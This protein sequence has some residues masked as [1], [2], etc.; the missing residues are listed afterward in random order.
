M[1]ATL[2]RGTT[3]VEL[4]LVEDGSGNPIAIRGVGKP[5][6]RIN[7]TGSINPRHTDQWSG[8]DQYTLV[9]RFIGTNAYQD[10]LTLADLA[11][12]NGAGTPLT[13]N[14]DSPEFDTDITVVP[15]A[16]Q[17]GAITLAYEPGTKNVVI[18]DVSLTRVSDVQGS[19]EQDATTP[20]ASGNGPIQLSRGNTTVD[21]ELDVT[22]DRSIG[23]PNDTTKRNV[24]TDPYY[25]SKA[26][27]AYDEFELSVTYTSNTISTINDLVDIFRP[28]LGRESLT[29]DFNGLYGMGAMSVVPTGSEAIRFVRS[30]GTNGISI[31]PKITLRR[32]LE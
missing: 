28:Q 4:P 13:L 1:K 9:G 31:I 32:V 24:D 14:I 25:I 16:G 29:L 10:A 20:T 30:S 21:L 6:L 26:K 12:T 2:S 19:I 27:S 5:N 18:A 8:L 11:K 7:D 3:S 17:Q 15:G 22:V 23:R